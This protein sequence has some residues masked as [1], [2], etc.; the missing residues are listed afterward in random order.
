M[1]QTSIAIIFGVL[2]AIGSIVGW[3]LYLFSYPHPFSNAS[4][5]ATLLVVFLLVAELLLLLIGKRMMALPVTWLHY[6]VALASFVASLIL[7]VL[8]FRFA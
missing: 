7:A 5:L 1:I 4:V 6:V 3:L 8:Y 2:G